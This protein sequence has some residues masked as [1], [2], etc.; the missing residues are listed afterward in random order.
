MGVRPRDDLLL[1]VALPPGV[2]PHAVAHPA[3]AAETL[4]RLAAPGLRNTPS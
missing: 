2:G 4:Q 3:V 1:A